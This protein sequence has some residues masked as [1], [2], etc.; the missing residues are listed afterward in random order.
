MASTK[1]DY[2]NEVVNALPE[3]LWLRSASNGEFLYCSPASALVWGCSSDQLLND[4]DAWWKRILREDLEN[5]EVAW[6][7][8]QQGAS[9]EAEYRMR[10]ADGSVRWISDRG[11]PIDSAPNQPVRITGLARDITSRKNLEAD[12]RKAYEALHSSVNGVIITDLEDQIIYTNPAFLSLFRFG[13]PEAAL[14]TK[15]EELF[16]G[17]DIEEL[18]DV[19]D[20]IANA[21]AASREF[22]V[23]RKDG[24]E[25][26]VEV[27]SSEV[28]DSQGEVV[29]SMASFIEVTERKLRERETQEHH[30]K[31]QELT[32]RMADLEEHERR[33]ISNLIHD[34]TVQSLALSNVRLGAVSKLLSDAQLHDAK[35]QLEAAREMITDGIRQ[36]RLVMADLSPPLLYEVGLGAALRQFA[37]RT[38]KQHGIRI[39]VHD[40]Q[41]GLAVPESLRTVFYQSARELVLNACKHAAPSSINISLTHGDGQLRLLTRDDG[42][43]FSLSKIGEQDSV[44]EGGYGLF[45]IRQRV[46]RLGGELR[47]ESNPGAGT[48]V[49]IRL[50]IELQD[51]DYPASVRAQC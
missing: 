30:R 4:R 42:S 8:C 46:K 26:F 16:V 10:N 44:E 7:Q 3:V 2:L 19:E 13:N 39:V 51:R 43:G 12:A 9:F 40:S 31:L 14:G 5:V 29:G 17:D 48:E 45:N 41:P 23:K 34:T 50:P 22:V 6:Q 11:I 32:Q 37:D 33:R 21:G 20:E 15:A 1:D 28:H 24:S 49:S 25:I 18:S 35:D 27:S 47:I 38:A 36:C